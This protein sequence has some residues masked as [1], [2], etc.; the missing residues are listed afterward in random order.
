MQ[1]LGLLDDLGQVKVVDLLVRLD[2]G[3]GQQ[4]LTA[5]TLPIRRQQILVRYGRLIPPHLSILL[6]HALQLLLHLP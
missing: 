4:D 1:L 2:R 3:R 6:P 5:L